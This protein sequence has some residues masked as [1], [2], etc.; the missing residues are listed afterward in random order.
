MPPTHSG[1]GLPQRDILLDG[2]RIRIETEGQQGK[3][4]NCCSARDL[5]RIKQRC[6]ARECHARTREGSHE[7]IQQPPTTL[8]LS[9]TVTL[10]MAGKAWN[11]PCSY[12]PFLFII[13]L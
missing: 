10:R 9:L 1:H 11:N 2:T 8:C 7:R 13:L 12:L 6:A 5:G 4:I 3:G